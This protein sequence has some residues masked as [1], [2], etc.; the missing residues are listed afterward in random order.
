MRN[1]ME[2]TQKTRVINGSLYVRSVEP[3]GY[4]HTVHDLGHGQVEA[5]TMPRYA[6]SEV[7]S[8]SPLA[9]LDAEASKGCVWLA[10]A[11]APAP[12][13]TSSQLLDRAAR[14]LER[15]SRRAKTKVRRLCKAKGLTTMLTLT[16]RENQ[17]DRGRMAR[18]FDVFIKRLRR[19]VPDLQY[20][21]VFEKQ[22]RGA[23]HAHI[24]VPRVLSHYLHKG[25]LLRSYDLLR[26]IWRA[27]VGSDNGN[28]DVSRNK[29]MG[30]SASRLASYLS[31][32][33]AKG[34]ASGFADGDSYRASGR[35]LPGPVRVQVMGSNMIEAVVSLYAL[36]SIEITSSKEFHSARLDCGGYFVTLSG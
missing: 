15:S 27:V 31:K 20:V 30:R 2:N 21:C 6:W 28:I 26:S 5:L 7:S 1:G 25:A 4:L 18:D 3:Y 33:I 34:F 9:L 22:A 13:L 8:L 23:Y 14:T 24:A 12:P 17:T 19:V 35:A 32:Y 29:K 11:W 36:I 16:Y 10:E